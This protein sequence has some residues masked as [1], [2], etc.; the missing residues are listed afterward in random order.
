MNRLST[1]ASGWPSKLNCCDREAVR[2]PRLI[3]TE[4]K[5]A[6]D[7]PMLG[8]Q[9]AGR[10][11]ETAFSRPLHPLDRKAGRWTAGQSTVTGDVKPTTTPVNLQHMQGCPGVAAIGQGVKRFLQPLGFIPNRLRAKRGQRLSILLCSMYSARLKPA[12]LLVSS[13]RFPT[14]QPVAKQPKS[15]SSRA[16]P[17][18]YRGFDHPGPAQNCSRPRQGE[19]S[20]FT[21]LL[22]TSVQRAVSAWCLKSL[23]VTALPLPEARTSRRGGSVFGNQGY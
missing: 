17:V 14:G 18:G 13:R 15:S 3:M 2:M 5:P 19:G 1:W 12:L 20:E 21:R 4:A 9:A 6:S 10:S 22:A 7:C 8:S 11:T 23:L 16:L